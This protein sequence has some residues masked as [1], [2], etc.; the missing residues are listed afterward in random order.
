MELR[1]AIRREPI[2]KAHARQQHVCCLA[3]PD[4]DRSAEV[5]DATWNELDLVECVWNIPAARM[6]APPNSGILAFLP[7]KSS[8]KTPLPQSIDIQIVDRKNQFYFLI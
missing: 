6:A 5:R 2:G 1:A 8:T 7:S 3:I 4:S